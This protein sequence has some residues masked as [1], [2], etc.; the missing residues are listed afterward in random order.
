MEDK[1]A[2]NGVRIITSQLSA[3][4][5]ITMHNKTQAFKV[6]LTIA[7]QLPLLD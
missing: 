3:K 4:Y 6:S 1:S 7:K 2:T 5:T